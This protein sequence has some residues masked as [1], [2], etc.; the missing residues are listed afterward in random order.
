MNPP[1]PGFHLPGLFLCVVIVFVFQFVGFIWS[2]T[3]FHPGYIPDL[4]ERLHQ[5]A[6]LG[7]LM[8]LPFELPTHWLFSLG[9]VFPAL[10]MPLR[11]L[12][13]PL[14]YGVALYFGLLFVFRRVSSLL[15]RIA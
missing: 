10:V 3:D 14:C 6:R 9:G 8:C 1:R 4:P 12:V 7:S 13:L 2:F 5:R 15:S 11:F